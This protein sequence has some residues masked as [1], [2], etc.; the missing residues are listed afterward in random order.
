MVAW[1]HPFSPNRMTDRHLWNHYLSSTWLAVGKATGFFAFNLPE[2]IF[3]SSV[4]TGLT[5][6]QMKQQIFLADNRT[7]G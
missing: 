7:M 5:F 1:G 4:V 6:E 2:G 3:V